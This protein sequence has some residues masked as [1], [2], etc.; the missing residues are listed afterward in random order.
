M[1][2][3]LTAGFN[4][5]IMSKSQAG[6]LPVNGRYGAGTKRHIGPLGHFSRRRLIS[7]AIPAASPT[8][9]PAM[10]D[11]SAAS[12]HRHRRHPAALTMGG[13]GKIGPTNLG[14]IY[15][16]TGEDLASL[17]FRDRPVQAAPMSRVKGPVTI[18]LQARRW[19]KQQA[20]C[21]RLAWVEHERLNA[22]MP[23]F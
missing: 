2:F 18:W 3:R 20:R 9:P 10:V 22:G 5:Q 8:T 12:R 4:A 6:V 1:R 15:H 13:E 16:W 17:K 7:E 21:R 14:A 23:Q 19:E 11:A